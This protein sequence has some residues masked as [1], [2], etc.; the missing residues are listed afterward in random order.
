MKEFK[1]YQIS[2][3]HLYDAEKIG[4]HGKY[5]ENR[6]ITDQKCVAESPA[7]VDAAF[8]KFCEDDEVEYI[9]ISGDLTYDGEK[10][11]HASLLEKLEVLK[12][13]GK[14]V[15]VTFATHDYFMQAKRYTEDG[16]E[17][18]PTYTRKELREL[19]KDYGWQ[20]AVSEHVPS[21]SYSVVPTEGLRLLLLNDDGNGRQFCGYYDDLILWI[22]NQ[23]DEA[24]EKGERIIAVTHHPV[25]PP[26]LIYPLF[27]H[28]DMLG[29]YETVTPMLADMG[30]E[31]V[32]TGHTHMQSIEYIDTD[33]GNRLYHINT[34]SAIAYPCPYRKVTVMENG[35]D[36][37]TFN[38][39]GFE[40]DLNGKTYDEYVKDHF[41]FMI[42]DLFNSLENDIEHFKVHASGISMDDAFVD[43][44]KPVLTLLGKIINNVTFKSLGRFT[45]TS[46]KIDKS[47]AD[48]RFMDVALD[49]V[50]GVFTGIKKYPPNTAEYKAL[51][52][53]AKRLSPVVKL[54]NHDGSRLPFETLMQDLL[55]DTGD[56]DNS[57]AFLPY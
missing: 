34:G 29:N 27:S 2:D 30:V 43:K 3:L 55:Y 54:K 19:Y 41:T 46:S 35:V 16:T 44:F 48:K 26:S 28:R 18:L 24:K 38:I 14:K 39:D 40:C 42:K 20:D 47:I 23:C 57:N 9:I 56:Y 33:K 5:F 13:A 51:M 21:Y 22:K 10:E 4:S 45:L 50:V 1:F 49:L 12:S 53:L 8:C 36:V 15:Y 7:I 32:F 52:A 17:K 31:F 37:K 25:L 11:N 6:C